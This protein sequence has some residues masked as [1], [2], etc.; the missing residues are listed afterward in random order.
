MK[1]TG[2]RKSFETAY[3]FAGELLTKLQSIVDGWKYVHIACRVIRA[4]TVA[5]T[6]YVAIST[7]VY[8]RRST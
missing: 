1:H 7:I 6:G 3:D 2:P 4:G 5:E 8:E